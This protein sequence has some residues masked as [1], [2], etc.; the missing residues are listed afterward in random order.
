MDTAITANGNTLTLTLDGALAQTLECFIY[1]IKT[2]IN[3][4]AGHLH[5]YYYRSLPKLE[6]SLLHLSLPY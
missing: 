4:A 1:S 2:A 5:W 3:E 6:K